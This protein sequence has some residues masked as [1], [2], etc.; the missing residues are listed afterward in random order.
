[1]EHLSTMSKG[2]LWQ[3]L[4]PLS[5]RDILAF[6]T[7]NKQFAV[8]CRD[9]QFWRAK[10]QHDFPWTHTIPE[11]GDWRQHYEAQLL[12]PR[13]DLPD[14]VY[15]LIEYIAQFI[16][17]DVAA[18]NRLLRVQDEDLIWNI[19]EAQA[20]L[21]AFMTYPPATLEDMIR[22]V[23]TRV[24]GLLNN[25]HRVILPQ[26]TALSAEELLLTL[27]DF[28]RRLYYPEYQ[29]TLDLS[30]L[31]A[32]RDIYNDV[33]YPRLDKQF[34]R[35]EIRNLLVE[36]T[37]EQAAAARARGGFIPMNEEEIQQEADRYWN[38][39]FIPRFLR[40]GETF[41][42]LPVTGEVI[43][44]LPERNA[45]P[46]L[47]TR[48]PQLPPTN[49]ALAYQ[50][51][52]Q[53]YEEEYQFL[54]WLA[55][56]P[57][58]IELEGYPTYLPQHIPTIYYQPRD[59]NPQLP[60]NTPDGYLNI[61]NPKIVLPAGTAS[62]PIFTRPVRASPTLRELV[63][64]P[65]YGVP[66]RQFT[67]VSPRQSPQLSPRQPN[68]SLTP[69]LRASPQLQQFVPVNYPGPQIQQFSPLSP[70]SQQFFPPGY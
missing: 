26:L 2:P 43:L 25:I 70:L 59:P 33:P 41:R 68:Q 62:T 20:S 8:V 60:L 57:E 21:T 1:M 64:Q 9:P 54:G 5:Y 65:N 51:G 44:R 48:L 14:E 17:N 52:W 13:Y 69:P 24:R 58:P 37:R 19:H 15:R 22:V 30:A 32:Y 3:T 63:Q 34:V 36:R 55:A 46:Q 10:L 39:P 4:L 28:F 23:Q 45:I 61:P 47:P 29:P 67:P 66:Q 50:V 56:T 11:A 16:W 35:G 12:Q 18:R 7:S 31:V 27:V 53:F 49:E 6:C 40:Q 38:P 42:H